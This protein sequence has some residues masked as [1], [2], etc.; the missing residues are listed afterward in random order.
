MSLAQPIEIAV[1]P[2]SAARQMPAPS[3]P[4]GTRERGQPPKAIAI[5]TAHQTATVAPAVSSREYPPF[6]TA[7]AT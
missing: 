7:S 5:S 1:Q 3:R 2:A 4:G 6:E